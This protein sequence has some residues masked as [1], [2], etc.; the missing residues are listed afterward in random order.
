[1]GSAAKGQDASI[2]TTNP[3]FFLSQILENNDLLRQ[4]E[5]TARSRECGNQGVTLLTWFKK[6]LC[7]EK[8]SFQD[9]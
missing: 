3:V 1:M 9:F 6:I 2:G 5:R 8:K 4:V 7:R